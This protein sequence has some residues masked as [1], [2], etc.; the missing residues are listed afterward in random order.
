MPI[1]Y[2]GQVA[3]G[4]FPILL[5]DDV[6]TS[7][8]ELAV[9]LLLM[10]Y[11]Y[12]R[13][14]FEGG[15][16]FNPLVTTA[17]KMP[18]YTLGPSN[19]YKEPSWPDPLFPWGLPPTGSTLFLPNIPTS[20]DGDAASTLLTTFAWGSPVLVPLTIGDSI[21]V[22][23]PDPDLKLQPDN[24]TREWGVCWAFSGVK[25]DGVT[26]PDVPLG[27]L[28]FGYPDDG[29]IGVEG[30]WGSVYDDWL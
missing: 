2:L 10:G 1:D 5:T 13:P 11:S 4:E 17:G 12:N 6:P 15:W 28:G 21:D 18:C 14:I 3:I 25:A 29:T 8:P 23:L 7:T 19:C 16:N 24:I 26:Y 22:I 27:Y 30:E 20:N 9:Y